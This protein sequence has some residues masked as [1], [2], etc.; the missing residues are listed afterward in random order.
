MNGKEERNCVVEFNYS[1]P[2][3]EFDSD[4]SLIFHTFPDMHIS[5]F[6]SFCKKFARAVGYG[7]TSIETYFGPDRDNPFV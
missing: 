5:T 3:N 6:H 7:E 4:V 1:N 2:D